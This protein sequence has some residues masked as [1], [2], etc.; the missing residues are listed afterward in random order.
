MIEPELFFADDM[1]LPTP[2]QTVL[3]SCS[4]LMQGHVGSW[5]ARARLA[6]H[7]PH[8]DRAA[9]ARAIMQRWPGARRE[10][11]QIF[12]EQKSASGNAAATVG[13]SLRYLDH[14]NFKKMDRRWPPRWQAHYH[15][16]LFSRRRGLQPI[17]ISSQPRPTIFPYPVSRKMKNVADVLAG[18]EW[19]DDGL[20]PMQIVF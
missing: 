16:W 5:Q 2:D 19:R 7:H 12:D 3:H 9:L 20:E 11:V 13:S 10:D 15:S 8:L 1:A 18:N 4:P 14:I 17:S 6:V